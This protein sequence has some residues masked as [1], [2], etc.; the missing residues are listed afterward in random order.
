[1]AKKVN[2]MKGLFEIRATFQVY[3]RVRE[4]YTFLPALCVA[5]IRTARKLYARIN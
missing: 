2:E 4:Y 1:M 3:L 5:H